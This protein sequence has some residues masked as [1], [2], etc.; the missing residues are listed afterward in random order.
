MFLIFQENI[1][2]AKLMMTALA[3]TQIL[4]LILNLKMKITRKKLNQ[5]RKMLKKDLLKKR[6]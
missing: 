2:T 3:Q 6:D 1:P 5:T 4:M